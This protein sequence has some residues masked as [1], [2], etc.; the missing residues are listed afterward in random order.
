MLFNTICS[1]LEK[2]QLLLNGHEQ[3]KRRART[4]A[5]FSAA[6]VVLAAVAFIG[7]CDAWTSLAA[8][9]QKEVAET[10]VPFLLPSSVRHQQLETARES[11]QKDYGRLAA[12]NGWNQEKKLVQQEITELRNKKTRL[13][14]EKQ[15]SELK[16]PLEKRTKQVR[17][18]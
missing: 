14:L 8:V 1:F 15:K 12:L 17:N 18:F 6:A 13:E 10:S 3:P 7:A 2:I 5:F 16:Q 11:I 4:T 9:A